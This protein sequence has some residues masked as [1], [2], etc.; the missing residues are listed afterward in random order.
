M[1]NQKKKASDKGENNQA[2]TESSLGEKNKGKGS[3]EK[4]KKRKR[5]KRDMSKGQYCME[6]KNERKNKKRRASKSINTKI[7][8]QCVTENS[9]EH[10]C[11]VENSK[12]EECLRRE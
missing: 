8:E 2:M 5:S 9:N 4:I 12:G 3:G 10:L 7:R 1:E 6:E 11:S